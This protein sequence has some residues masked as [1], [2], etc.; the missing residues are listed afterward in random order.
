MESKNDNASYF[1]DY[2][3]RGCLCIIDATIQKQDTSNDKDAV[4]YYWDN[5]KCS[6]HPESYIRG[7]SK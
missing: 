4:D 3:E 1:R 2:F 7:Y 6:R 5:C